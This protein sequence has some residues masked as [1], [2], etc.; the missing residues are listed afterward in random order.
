VNNLKI[1]VVVCTYNRAKYLG[2]CIESLLRQSISPS[3]YEILIV[4]NNSSDSSAEICRQYENRENFRYFLEKKQGLSYARNRGYK[5]SRAPIVAY[6]DDDAL[7]SDAWLEELLKAFE[8][9]EVGA[10]GGPI[11]PIY[12]S[13]I[14]N[15]FHESLLPLFS[16]RDCGKEIFDLKPNHFFYGVN[17]AIRRDILFKSGGFRVDLGRKGNDLLSDEELVVFKE[18][19]RAGYKKR[20]LPEAVIHHLLP[21]D[22]LNIKWLLRRFYWLGSGHA[23]R[24][25][26]AA[27]SIRKFNRMIYNRLIMTIR[28]F[29][30]PRFNAGIYSRF[31]TI[32][33]LLGYAKVIIFGSNR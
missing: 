22:R 10:A 17:M 28:D 1:S 27:D 14:P 23:V 12:E 18:I 24:Q 11:F 6:T 20:Y 8:D 31:I 16:C 7:A 29:N 5:E 26:E 19:E 3:V 30:R 25:K 4:D 9:D 15:W 13:D 21:K 32:V 33:M 2:K